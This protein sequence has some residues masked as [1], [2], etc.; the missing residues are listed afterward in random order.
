[1]GA[2]EFHDLLEKSQRKENLLHKSID[3]TDCICG[4]NYIIK[5]AKNSA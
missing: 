1:M 3:Y 5:Q 2:C 4:N